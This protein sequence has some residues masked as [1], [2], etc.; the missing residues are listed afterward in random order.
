M[1][2]ELT[3]DR[4]KQIG[5][6]IGA[7]PHPDVIDVHVALAAAERGH[8]ALASDGA[9]IAEVNP[10]LVLV[11][12]YPAQKAGCGRRRGAGDSTPVGRDASFT[13]AGAR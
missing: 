1:I 10:A 7:T 5:I 11:H 4:A 9:D 3:P 2:D 12:V 8:A 6:T 13:L